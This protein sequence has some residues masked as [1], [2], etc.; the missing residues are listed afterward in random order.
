MNRESKELS[1]IKIH[2]KWKLSALWTSVM[3][4]YVYGDYFGLYRPGKLQMLLDGRMPIGPTTQRVL[5][6][7]AALMAIPSLM[8][9]LSLVLRPKV[10]RWV[11]IVF[12]V[13][14]TVIML[15]TMP[16]AWAFYIFLG[17]IEV[18][19]TALIVWYAWTWPR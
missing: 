8:V 19:L 10:N 17:I 4:C 13:L 6:G 1:D 2:V 16:G 14:F 7:T 12:G 11:N 18:V 9:F 3:F 5:L 15:I